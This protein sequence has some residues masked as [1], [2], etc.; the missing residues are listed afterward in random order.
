MI[1]QVILNA[2]KKRRKRIKL[3]P[4]KPT[5]DGSMVLKNLHFDLD[6]N[7]KLVN[8]IIKENCKKT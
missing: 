6:N 7:Q 3:Q 5:L 4:P 8:T 2:F 1:I